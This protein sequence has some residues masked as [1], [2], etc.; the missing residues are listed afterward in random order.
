MTSR[1]HDS[2]SRSFVPQRSGLVAE[3]A[4]FADG[5]QVSRDFQEVL[6]LTVTEARRG[7]F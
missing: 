3:F 1:R 6:G 7:V 4:G 5:D 2:T